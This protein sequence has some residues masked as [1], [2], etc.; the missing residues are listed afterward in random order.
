MNRLDL[1]F[2]NILNLSFCFIVILMINLL[3]MYDPTYF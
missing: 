2:F 1:Y 3:L